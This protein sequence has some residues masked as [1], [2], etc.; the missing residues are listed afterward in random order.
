M[1]EVS[2]QTHAASKTLC[3]PTSMRVLLAENRAENDGRQ[4]PWRE[5]A[6]LLACSATV[7]SNENFIRTN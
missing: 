5:R 6:P 3:R 4:G 2:K 1:Y 7:L